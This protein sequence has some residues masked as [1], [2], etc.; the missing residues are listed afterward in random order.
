MN[1]FKQFLLRGNV[2][3]LA[4]GVVMG[5][6]FG[7]VVTALVKDFITPLIAAIFGKPDFS[8]ISFA[9]NGST[10][11]VGDFINAV[12][13]FILVAIAVFFFVVKPVNFLM[14]RARREPPADP[15]TM[16]C[17]E[18]MSEIPIGAKRCAFCTTSLPATAR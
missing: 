10:F 18:C 14:S 12:I 13:A 1:D 16:K 9:V 11:G 4:V 5:A 3:D 6:A 15:T 2:V 8:A 7:T 17:P